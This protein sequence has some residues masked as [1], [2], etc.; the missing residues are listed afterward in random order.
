MF[1][2]IDNCKL[3]LNIRVSPNSKKNKIISI[4]D[5]HLKI[6]IA[7]PASDDKAN[8]ELIDY[9]A[10]L[11]LV[12]KKNIYFI[13]GFKSKNKR[14]EIVFNDES[15]MKSIISKIFEMIQ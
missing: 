9:L 12:K 5:L 4:D 7:A 10:E 13:K 3:V 14:I 1:Y 11:L 6:A 8:E 15:I 2:K